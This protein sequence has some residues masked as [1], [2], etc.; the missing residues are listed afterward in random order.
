MISASMCATT[1]QC[2]CQEREDVNVLN[3][4]NQ[5]MLKATDSVNVQ[6]DLLLI[7]SRDVSVLMLLML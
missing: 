6:V 2:S 7:L 4:L 3:G 5:E 1:V